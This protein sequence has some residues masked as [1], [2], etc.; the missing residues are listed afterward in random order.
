MLRAVGYR[1]G[2]VALSFLIEAAFV[3]VLG[4]VS[5]T[6]LGVVL[7]RNLF[8]SEELAG[9]HV[10]FVIPWDMISGILALTVGMAL[11]M[12]WLPARQASQLAPAEALRY[13]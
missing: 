1:R 13:E 10:D 5:G 2:L 7:A 6:I 9:G 11:L 8:T 3:V 4:V 12:T